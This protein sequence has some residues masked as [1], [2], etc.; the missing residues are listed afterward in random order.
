MKLKVIYRGKPSTGVEEN[1]A[2]HK[3]EIVSPGLGAPTP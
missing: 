2:D 1:W 3:V